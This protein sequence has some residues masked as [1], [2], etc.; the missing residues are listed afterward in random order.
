MDIAQSAAQKEIDVVDLDVDFAAASAHKF[1]GPSGM[2][3]LYG[4]YD[5]L[6]SLIPTY[7]GGSTVINS[8]YE[9]YKLLPPPSCF[10]AGLQDYAGAIG[11]GTAAEYVMKVGRANIQE[12]E[13][14]LNR[15][16][17]DKLLNLDKVSIVGPSDVSKRGGICSF[18]IDGWDP[19]EIAMHLDEEYNIAIRSGMHCV[20]SWFN[21]RGIEGTA[22]ASAYLYNNEADVISFASAIEE[23]VNQ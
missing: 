14:R 7:V 12:H 20:H 13:N 21:S 16:M 18:N 15:I 2:G 3:F 6:S 17:S 8:T 22:R 4:K 10:E 23:I 11:S 19:T 1:C 5:S 9:D